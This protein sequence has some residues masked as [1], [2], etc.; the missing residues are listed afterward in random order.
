MSYFRFINESEIRRGTYF[1]YIVGV[2]PLTYLKFLNP[3]V[4]WNL[5]S[6]YKAFGMAALKALEASYLEVS[7][8]S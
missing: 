3:Q 2:N 4:V 1:F 6:K 8:L 7:Y 5:P